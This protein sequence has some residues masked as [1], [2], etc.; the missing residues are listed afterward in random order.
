MQTG[1]KTKT[2]LAVPIT[3]NRSHN[4]VITVI[5]NRKLE[6][7]DS[8]NEFEQIKARHGKLNDKNIKLRHT[9]QWRMWLE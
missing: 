1:G 5:T 2:H 7:G 8:L 3:C 6:V 4:K 9:R